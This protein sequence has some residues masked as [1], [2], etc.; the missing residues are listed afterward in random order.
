MAE[1]EN[2]RRHTTSAKGRKRHATIDL[3]QDDDSIAHLS[4][5]TRLSQRQS[6]ARPATLY[7]DLG[8]TPGRRNTTESWDSR[9][10]TLNS[11]ITRPT[12]N[13]VDQPLGNDNTVFYQ[14]IGEC[15]VHGIMNREAIDHQIVERLQRTIFEIR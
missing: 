10:P 14:M 11:T 8:R 9:Q 7:P 4:K 6:T 13:H 15:Y 3:D 5:H 2:K 12:R 1:K